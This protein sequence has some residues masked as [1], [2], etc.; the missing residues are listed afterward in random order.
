[1]RTATEDHALFMERSVSLREW[2][3]DWYRAI[4]L[5][6]LCEAL[7]EARVGYHY[8][9]RMGQDAASLMWRFR[10]MRIEEELA[11]RSE[12]AV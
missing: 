8:S 3:E 12:V 6:V 9:S 7:R 2:S 10:L 4:S 5:D 1:M 11:Q